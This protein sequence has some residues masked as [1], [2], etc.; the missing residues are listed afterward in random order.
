MMFDWD[1]L[2]TPRHSSTD[3]A[4]EVEAD[5]VEISPRKVE[6]PEPMAEPV[7]VSDA[8]DARRPLLAE[9]TSSVPEP[10][11]EP[12]S[13][14]GPKSDM[15]T[16]GW[17][18]TAEVKEHKSDRQD[19]VCANPESEVCAESEVQASAELEFQCGTQSKIQSELSE[20]T[21]PQEKQTEVSENSP[22]NRIEHDIPTAQQHGKCLPEGN[23][24]STTR[25]EELHA[26]QG[27][28]RWAV[29]QCLEFL[30]WA[31]ILVRS[32]Q[33][34]ATSAPQSVLP[35]EAL[36]STLVYQFFLCIFY[37]FALIFHD[38]D[39][40]D[41]QK[42][43]KAGNGGLIVVM[44]STHGA[45]MLA[46]GST[47]CARTG[48]APR[49]FLHRRAYQL[50]PILKHLGFVSGS[51]DVAVDL[52]RKGFLTMT[53]PGGVGEALRGHEHAY[54]LHTC[55]DERLGYAY[56]AKEAG[57]KVYPCFTQNAEEMHFVP[58]FWLAHR[59]RLGWL[60]DLVCCIPMLGAVAKWIVAVFWLSASWVF[61]L[62]IPVKVTTFC[63]EPI[64]TD[65]LSVD[66]IAQATKAEMLRLIK[67]HQ[68]H[69]H[70]YVPGLLPRLCATK[71]S[72]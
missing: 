61:A 55:W 39:V 5:E 22:K 36:S 66:E 53:A 24:S 7:S 1:E 56:A 38:Y 11:V 59:L 20:E 31:M 62:P 21:T 45:D 8:L 18:L 4:D 9:C 47:I 29:H 58:A 68:P 54:S 17:P 69:G 6:V 33:V 64:D 48:R 43:P 71:K 27:F 51:R 41:L 37:R 19:E 60:Y 42:L 10:M 23:V 32:L 49:G 16:N 67:H 25:D 2:D 14:Y 46:L 50:L 30:T 70:A 40:V 28:L 44:Y 34:P 72:N 13:E 26:K 35:D 65:G 15:K 52:L 57:V 3:K 63:G 12:I